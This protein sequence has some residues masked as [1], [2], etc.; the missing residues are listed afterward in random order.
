MADNLRLNFLKTGQS[1]EY[2][3]KAF[4]SSIPAKIQIMRAES[5]FPDDTAEREIFITGWKKDT[6]RKS[7]LTFVSLYHEPGMLPGVY[8]ISLE[9]TAFKKG[10]QEY[11]RLIS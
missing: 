10:K 5:S 9:N 3:Q 2:F 4:N 7:T 11:A 1:I 6:A 8:T